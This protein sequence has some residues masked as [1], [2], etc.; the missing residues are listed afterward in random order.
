MKNYVIFTE[1][2]TDLPAYMVE[3]LGIEVIPMT[4]GFD[5]ET[6]LNY[7]D[8]RELGILEF[9]E[10]IKNGERST[11][12]LINSMTFI[13][14]FEPIL[15]RGDD[16]LYI[17]FS[18]GLSGTYESSL[19]AAEQLMEKYKGSKIL[20]V[21][22]K[23]ASMGEG[24]LVYSAV[25][26][27]EEGLDIEQLYQWVVDNRLKLCH[28]VTVDDLNHLKRGGRI[29]AVTATLGSAL[30]VKPIIHVDDDGH[31]IPVANIRG[32]KKS[33]HELLEHMVETCTNPEEQVIFISHADCFDDVDYLAN[34]IKDKLHVKDVILN[35]MGPVIGSHTGQGAIALFFFGTHR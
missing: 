35:Y 15:K 28:W 17:G 23:A 21:D 19:L 30:N 29:S 31:L 6:Y 4:F 10:R 27:K 24:L 16:I 20:C 9:Y 26:K 3:E 12:T 8:H 25:K 32:R 2:T 5:N 18:S 14:Y 34:I 7:S 11:T 13:E 1:S 22:T 33:I